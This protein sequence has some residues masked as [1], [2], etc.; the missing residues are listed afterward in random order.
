MAIKDLILRDFFI[1]LDRN[2]HFNKELRFNV[3]FFYLKSFKSAKKGK[4]QK[5]SYIKTPF[6][7]AE[8]YFGFEDN[9]IRPLKF[10]K[11]NND[12]SIK[13]INPRLFKKFLLN[14]RNK[15]VSFSDQA[16]PEDIIP[17]KSMLRNF[18]VKEENILNLTFCKNCLEKKEFTLLNNAI[19]IKSNLN[20]II[21]PDCALDLVINNAKFSGAIPNE[22]INP[23]LKNFF[24][25]LLLKFKDIDKVLTY[26]KA[27][28]NPVK[29]RNMTQYDIE[30]DQP[31]NKKYLNYKLDN[32][33][34]PKPL[35]KLFKDLNIKTLLPIQAISIENG[36]LHEYSDQLI[37]SPT[38]S[39][40]TLIGEIAGVSKLLNNKS[41]KM[42]YLVPIVALA[43]IRTEEFMRKYSA[44]SLKIVKKIGESLLE[45]R[46]LDDLE[47]MADA[48]II[49]ATYE[50]LD[51]ILRSGNKN[52]IGNVSTF[53]IDEI[54]TLIEPERG[55]I[56]DGLISRLKYLYPSAQFLYLSATIGQPEELSKKLNAKLIQ[57][58]NR[59]VPIER[60]LLLCPNDNV[61][62]RYMVDLVQSAFHSQ[63]K[64]KY[65]GQS[66][67]FTN[68]RKKC[69]NL[70]QYFQER[71]VNV[72]AYHS[73]LSC[74]VRKIIESEFQAQKIAGVVA[75]S[76]LAAGVDLPA[77][78]V[79]F[80]TLTMGIKTLTVAEFEQMLGRAGRLKKH[81]KGIVYLLVE[82]GKKYFSEHEKT[83]DEIAIKLLN[84]KIRDF[85]LEPNEDRFLT[86]LLAFISI[87]EEGMNLQEIFQFHE[88]LIN[89]QHDVMLSLNKLIELGLIEYRDNNG[90][91]RA[92]NMGKAIAKSFLLIDKCLEIIHEVKVDSKPLIE[93][94]LDLKPIKNVYLSKKV[95]ASLSRNV[96]MK[97]YSNNFFSAS[98]LSL[99]DA[100]HVKKRKKFSQDFIDLVLKWTREIFNCKCKD[101]PFCDCGRI[102]FQK[103]LL[104]L[105]IE[106]KLSLEQIQEYLEENYKILVYLGDLVDFFENLIYSLESLKNIV[107]GLNELRKSHLEELRGIPEVIAKIKMI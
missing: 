23:K 85:E 74:E 46:T 39:G 104:R 11:I 41:K 20:Q 101:N 70:T 38:S 78:Q 92:T 1:V 22:E 26:F 73:G 15:F 76:A 63:S 52:K 69:E 90:I 98:V 100:E 32:V 3:S 67:I 89:N 59:P 44:L 48:D 64:Y 36:L 35:K 30:G 37:M 43:N 7:R 49:I 94:A 17:I 24:R 86:E 62:K 60:H 47:D 21:C 19:K 58:N 2:V 27:D 71:G 51:Y 80:E 96:N 95:V 10:D 18:H 65:R 68:S 72:R 16:N 8:I 5:F 83:E 55:T 84:G 87:K 33:D 106:D 82:P 12:G 45:P 25:H 40:K 4:K 28:F 29:N 31:I 105:R 42:I 93:I 66:I 97:Y 99:M 13:P 56:L 61:K 34:I 9:K 79:I 54:Q 102:N 14:D 88:N 6:L 107:E 53:I 103:I 57:Y 81:E 75:T 50:A 91:Y 77:K